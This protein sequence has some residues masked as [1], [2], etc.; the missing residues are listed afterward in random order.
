MFDLSNNGEVVIRDFYMEMNCINPQEVELTARRLLQINKR[1]NLLVID[2]IDNKYWDNLYLAL[3]RLLKNENPQDIF[4]FTC[5]DLQ[6]KYNN[7]TWE[8]IFYTRD[9]GKILRPVILP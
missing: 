3:E 6:P 4:I 2:P 7:I 1:I 5:S 8:P 9:G